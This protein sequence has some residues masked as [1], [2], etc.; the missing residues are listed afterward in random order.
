MEKKGEKGSTAASD[1]TIRSGKRLDSDGNQN[2]NVLQRK[3]ITE[4]KSS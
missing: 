2:E 1:I 4:G 3:R